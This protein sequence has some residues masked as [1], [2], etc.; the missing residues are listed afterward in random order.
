MLAV[1]LTG[2]ERGIIQAK[3][4]IPTYSMFVQQMFAEDLPTMCKAL[5]WVAV[6]FFSL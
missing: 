3:G 1:L 5:C 4:K 2:A 6:H